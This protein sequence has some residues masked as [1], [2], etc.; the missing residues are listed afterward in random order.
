[1]LAGTIRGPANEGGRLRFPDGLRGFAALAVVFPHST[2]LFALARPNAAS[3]F[4]VENAHYGANGVP[5]FYVI[6]GFVIA[7][8]LRRSV[9]TPRTAGAFLLRR[10]IRLDPP[11]WAAIALALAVRV[12]QRAVAGATDWPTGPAVVAHLLYLQEILGYPEINAVFWTLCQE[13]QFYLAFAT[14]LAIVHFSAGPSGANPGARAATVFGAIYV[15][16][17]AW[18]AHLLTVPGA[19]VFVLANFHMFLGG[20]LTWWTLDGLLSE[21]AWWAGA[22]LL[23]LCLALHPIDWEAT[24]LVTTA[25]LYAAGRWNTM[26]TWLRGRAIQYL[27]RISYSLYLVHVPIAIVLLGLRTRIAPHSNAVAFIMLGVL[28]ALVIAAAHVMHWAVEAPCIRWSK[29]FKDAAAAPAR[30]PA[31]AA[32]P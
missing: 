18:P 19:H 29:R 3:R 11:Y 13:F 1:M 21:R 24:C 27:G 31:E 20:A 26:S 30:V 25:A 2:G 9:M 15:A 17:L 23:A 4:V 8:A 10:S 32:L 22:G 7:Y 5:V 28:F 6:S 12:L 16:S 14:V